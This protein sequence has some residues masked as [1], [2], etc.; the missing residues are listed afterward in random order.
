MERR[1]RVLFIIDELDIGGTEQQILEL[2]KRLDRDRYVPMVACFR[3]GRVSAEIESAGVRARRKSRS[4][5]QL[6]TRWN[7][8][9]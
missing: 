5:A 8:S 9:V 1:A 6:C 7:D 3:P 4:R 2:V